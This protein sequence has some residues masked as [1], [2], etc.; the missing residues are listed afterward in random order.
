MRPHEKTYQTHPLDY[1]VLVEPDPN[2]DGDG[3]LAVADLRVP[4]DECDEV[5]ALLSAAP[6]MA[7]AL[8]ALMEPRQDKSH[9]FKGW[10]TAWSAETCDSEMCSGIRAALT[11]AGVLP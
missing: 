2:A 11:K 5:G 1:R 6:D 7:R 3:W 9:H 8:L 10:C 4:V